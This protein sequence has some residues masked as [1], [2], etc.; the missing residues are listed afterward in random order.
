MA[1][2][3]TFRLRDVLRKRD[4]LLECV[5]N[6]LVGRSV[7][8][9]TLT[10]SLLS[11]L[12]VDIPY[13]TLF[14]SVRYLSGQRLTWAPSAQLAW[15]LAGNIS[16][17]KN[18]VPVHPWTVQRADEWVPLQVLRAT[19]TRDRR[20]N[21]VFN[22][23]FR[24]MAGTSCPMKINGV[25]STRAARAIASQLG[26]SRPWGS[27]PYR[28]PYDLVGLRLMG[29]IEAA[30]S[31][32]APEFHE[33]YC[34]DSFRKWNRDNVLKLRLRVGRKC[35]N[36]FTFACRQCA[37][38]YDVCAAATHPKT[39]QTG[40]CHKCGNSA[41]L[42]DPEDNSAVCMGCTEKLR[43]QPREQH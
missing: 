27:Y 12:P 9:D 24:V 37:Y 20:N 34:S 16:Q 33:I 8:P 17:L 22:M 6:P 38:G 25:W 19:K 32:T 14:E 29:M 21:F 1:G 10:A 2:I 39:Y 30:R 31:R 35:P 36:N 5:F 11:H 3:P 43:L 18:G 42:F 28:S 4:S 41:A 13:D 40:D 26:F 7:D 23:L 15:R